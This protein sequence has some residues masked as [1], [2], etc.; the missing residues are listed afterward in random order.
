MTVDRAMAKQQTHHL[1]ATPPI[2]EQTPSSPANSDQLREMLTESEV[3]ALTK[4]SRTSLF[5]LEKKGLFPPGV[6]VAPNTKRYFRDRI[7]AWQNALDEHDHFDPAR[8]R[9]KGRRRRAAQA[10]A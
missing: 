1:V 3:L 4:L 8:G 5:R 7:I 6:Y 9:G 2:S 10:L